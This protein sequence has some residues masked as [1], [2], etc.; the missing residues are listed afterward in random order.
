MPEE[1]FVRNLFLNV[2]DGPLKIDQLDLGV[3]NKSL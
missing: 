2:R 1:G 3:L